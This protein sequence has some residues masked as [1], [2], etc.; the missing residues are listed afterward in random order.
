MKKVIITP[1]INLTLIVLIALV[2]LFVSNI[3]KCLTI[4]KVL[5]DVYLCKI[6]EGV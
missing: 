6:F 5:F 3:K 4:F 2:L 1:K